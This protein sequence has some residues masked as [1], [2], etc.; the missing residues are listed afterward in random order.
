MKIQVIRS[1]ATG[2]ILIALILI[3]WGLD[4]IGW[5]AGW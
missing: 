4:P 1:L 2:M 3:G 5:L